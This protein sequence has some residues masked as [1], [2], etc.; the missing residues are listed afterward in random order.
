MAAV[1]GCVAAIRMKGAWLLGYIIMVSFVVILQFSFGVAAATLGNVEKVPDSMEQILYNDYDEID[2][3][4]TFSAL[5]PSSCYTAVNNR[6]QG[7]QPACYWDQASK[8]D[9]CQTDYTKCCTTNN[10]CKFEEPECTT[11]MRCVTG[12]LHGIGTPVAVVALLTLVLQ[13]AAIFWACVV[14]RETVRAVSSRAIWSVPCVFALRSMRVRRPCSMEKL[15][16]V[17]LHARLAP[18]SESMLSE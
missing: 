11:A 2:W 12:F 10:A 1:M 4:K 7:R 14:R 13:L 8:R 18:G 9:M 3:E 6:T 16:Q 5:L 15:P 17:M